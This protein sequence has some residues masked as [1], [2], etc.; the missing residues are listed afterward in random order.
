M[1]LPAPAGRGS[2]SKKGG[3]LIESVMM[4][5]LIL[6]LLIG[7]IEL[8]GRP[9]ALRRRAPQNRTCPFPCI[10]SALG[11]TETGLVGLVTKHIK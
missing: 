5:P 1:T 10:W 11:S 3:A 4:L 2:E 9:G 8:A 6:S 7:T